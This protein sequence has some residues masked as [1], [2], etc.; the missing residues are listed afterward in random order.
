[1]KTLFLTLVI[2]IASLS[3]FGQ[4]H[5]T[6]LNVIVSDFIDETDGYIE[7]QSTDDEGSFA[8][9][10]ISEALPFTFIIR[11][12]RIIANSY[13]DVEVIQHWTRMK[14]D[15][16]KGYSS[17]WEITTE[18]KTYMLWLFYMEDTS[19]LALRCAPY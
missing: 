2:M 9:L 7:D 4:R 14:E 5:E 17:L 15:E 19:A 13:S 1:M 18:D 8:Y 10:K 16:L 6:L 12:S 3:S 11:A